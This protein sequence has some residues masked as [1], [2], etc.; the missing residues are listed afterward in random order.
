MFLAIHLFYVS[1]STRLSR[2]IMTLWDIYF[3][4]DDYPR[5]AIFM[6]DFVAGFSTA[7]ASA[8]AD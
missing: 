6:G 2:W 8:A 4:Y 5:P 3:F 7:I 1:E